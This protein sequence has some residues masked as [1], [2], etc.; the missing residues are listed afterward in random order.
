MNAL[1]S[2][3]QDRKLPLTS[4]K[5]SFFHSKLYRG[6]ICASDWEDQSE[7][8]HI[9]SCLSAWVGLSFRETQECFLG[10]RCWD[11]GF[12]L[13]QR[14]E[15]GQKTGYL[16][17]E[18]GNTNWWRALQINLIWRLGE[19]CDPCLLGPCLFFRIHKFTVMDTCSCWIRADIMDWHV[20]KE[21]TVHYE[22]LF[23]VLDSLLTS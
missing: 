4:L 20:V 9:L 19:P 22:I 23:H 14:C 16:K 15:F 11:G 3:I 7:T 1:I 6:V 2:K 13:L 17:K 21:E 5:R 18:E 12:I 8:C 10:E